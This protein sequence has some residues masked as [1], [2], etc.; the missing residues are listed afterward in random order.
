MS[1]SD[2]N[3]RRLVSRMGAGPLGEELEATEALEAIAKATG[4]RAH[5]WMVIKV[6]LLWQHMEEWYGW[7]EKT[8]RVL[9]VNM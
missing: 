8:C 1:V 9:L 6:N 7:V 3:E 4:D 5:I 2:Y